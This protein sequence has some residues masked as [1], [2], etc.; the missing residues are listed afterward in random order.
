MRRKH[1]IVVVSHDRDLST[2]T[3]RKA[4]IIVLSHLTECESQHHE[5][6]NRSTHRQS[7]ETVQRI[8]EQP[9]F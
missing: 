8:Q 6:Q 7:C 2:L 1:Q 4:S 5:K 3:K 9:Q